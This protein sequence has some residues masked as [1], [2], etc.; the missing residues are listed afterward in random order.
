MR[1]LVATLALAGCSAAG[2]LPCVA[3]APAPVEVGV[4]AGLASYSEMLGPEHHGESARFGSGWVVGIQAG[5]W[6]TAR[7]GIRANGGYADRPLSLGSSF[8]TTQVM[9]EEIRLWSVSGDL[10]IRP[11]PGPFNVGGWEAL[12]FV[13]LGAGAK[14]VHFVNEAQLGAVNGRA[15]SQH[16]IAFVHEW[17]PMGVVAA[18]ADVPISDRLAVRFEAGDRFWNPPVRWLGRMTDEAGEI[19]HEPYAQ[20]GASLL[21]PWGLR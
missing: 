4:H 9:D 10:L 21:L 18:G 5:Y 17:E 7:F 2:T 19:V 12:P 14:R 6:P 20:V 3:Q 16:S 8:N 13:A 1:K 15:F 11:L